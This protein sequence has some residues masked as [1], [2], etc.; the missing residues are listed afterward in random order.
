MNKA[1]KSIRIATI[2]WLTDCPCSCNRCADLITA[3][4]ELRRAEKEQ[5]GNVDTHPAGGTIEPF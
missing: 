2:K 3:L 5:A 1:L 4:E